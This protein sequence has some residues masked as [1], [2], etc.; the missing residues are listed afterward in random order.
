MR[1]G[2]IAVLLFS[3]MDGLAQTK[4]TGGPQI[5]F[6]K[7]LHDFGKVKESSIYAT[8]RYTFVNT[9]D[10]PLFISSVQSSCGCTV[11]DWTRDTIRP[12]DSG[13]VQAKYE[14]INRPGTFQKTVT[15]YSNATNAPF[16]HLDF[17]GEVIRDEAPEGAPAIPDY[18]KVYFSKPTV[19]FGVI[20]D[21]QTDTQEIRLVNGSVYTTE[22]QPLQNI[23]AWCRVLGFPKS[24]EPN[25]NAVIQVILD[26]KLLKGFG[27][28][29]FEIPV[30]SDNA[31]TP[32]TG[33]YITYTRKLWFPKLN[34]RELARAPKLVVDKKLHNF[35]EAKSGDFLSTEFL[36]TNTGKQELKLYEMHPDCTCLKVEYDRDVLKPGEKMKVKVTF[37][38]VLKNGNANQSIWVV[39]NDPVTPERFISVH[40]HLPEQVYNCPTCPK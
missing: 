32:Y 17:V 9:G 28:G 3:L 4:A 20:Y 37:D 13:F 10:K 27:F 8:T 11:P 38:T 5:M 15:V 12:G 23:P 30:A 6:R 14:T 40:A 33:M 39:C 35:G 2:I 24:L 34:A 16:Y 21:N 18:G 29:A 19:D 26:G 1:F 7:R 36:F 25:E 22:F 31:M